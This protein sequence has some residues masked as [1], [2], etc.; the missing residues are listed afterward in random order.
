MIP[1]S[2]FPERIPGKVQS[3]RR[4]ALTLKT[5]IFSWRHPWDTTIP[6]LPPCLLR[7]QFQVTFTETT[8][9]ATTTACTQ[10]RSAWHSQSIFH[11]T[12]NSFFPKPCEVSC[13][14]AQDSHFY[15]RGSQD[16]EGFSILPC[17]RHLTRVE[18]GSSSLTTALF[19]G[20]L[21][22]VKDG[23]EQRGFTS[24]VVI[25]WHWNYLL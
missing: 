7:V 23:A 21:H 3:Q 24:P 20:L 16:T 22:L 1:I 8:E 13:G 11:S 10:A 4:T 9:A 12:A 25:W 14:Q 15:R 19:P 6:P 2:T 18:P 5:I 17:V